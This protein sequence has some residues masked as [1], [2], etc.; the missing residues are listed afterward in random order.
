MFISGPCCPFLFLHLTFA[1]RGQHSF[2]IMLPVFKVEYTKVAKAGAKA[3]C[4]LGF[5]SCHHY[6]EQLPAT[7]PVSSF[8]LSI[9]CCQ[10]F[11]LFN[12]LLQAHFLPDSLSRDNF[13]EI[14]GNLQTA[15]RGRGSRGGP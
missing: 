3:P 7:A 5:S 4:K 15:G 14:K 11:H 13:P 6:D 8:L 10:S 1:Y 12:H 2:L 9:A